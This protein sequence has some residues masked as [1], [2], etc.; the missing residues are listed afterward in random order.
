MSALINLLKKL[1][2]DDFVI[3][4][5]GAKGKIEF[6][7]GIEQLSD[8]HAFEPHPSEF[9]ILKKKYRTHPFKKLHLYKNG[10]F[11]CVGKAAF[12]VSN[13]T[14]MSSILKPDLG[15]YNKHFGHYKAFQKWE[16]AITTNQSIEINLTTIDEFFI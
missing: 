13:N 4:D 6:V 16:T 1:G 11:D 2:I 5:V 14:S 7:D 8:V 10:L 3:I 15:N 12:N 9:E